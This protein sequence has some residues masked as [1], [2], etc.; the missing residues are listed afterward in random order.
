MT[1]NRVN[2]GAWSTGD[3]LTSGQANGL[4]L[5]TTYALDKRSGQTDTLSSVVTL[6]SAGRIIPTVAT[7]ADADST[8]TVGS[9]NNYIYVPTLSANRTYTLSTTGAAT[10]DE[11]T[12]VCGAAFYELTVAGV[13][14]L[15]VLGTLNRAD[16]T[17]ARFLY[18]GTA[19]MLWNGSQGSR[20]QGALITSNQTWVCPRGVNE[21]I[22]IGIG[23]GGGGGGAGGP[24]GPGSST[25]GGGS[26]GAG[27]GALMG[28]Y[29]VATSPG[30]SYSI[31]IGAGGSAGAAGATA[32]GGTGGGNGGD[33]LFD[34]LVTFYGARGGSAGEAGSSAAASYVAGGS[35]HRSNYAGT[36]AAT[37]GTPP[38]RGGHGYRFPYTASPGTPSVGTG[39]SVAT[40]LGGAPGA[41][42]S[43]VLCG[44]GGGG[45]GGG[46]CEFPGSIAGAGGTGGTGSASTGADGTAGTAGTLGGGG[47]GGGGGGAGQTVAGASAAGGAGGNGA[48]LIMAVK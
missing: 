3:K 24:Q 40:R 14:T 37:D 10:G 17:W 25:S 1:I 38:G 15:Y 5:N 36:A 28:I 16:G 6:A 12:I 29:R 4:D 23:G 22:A 45:G 33:T 42:G 30:T 48:L 18:N 46:A 11:I 39:G 35:S 13:G 20:F 27:G 34:S 47:G 19:W 7:G 9:A 41:G 44:G 43:I 26:G 32:T 31:T 2:A 8:I 21:V